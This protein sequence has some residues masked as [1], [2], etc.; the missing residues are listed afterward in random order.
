MLNNLWLALPQPWCLKRGL[1][2][3]SKKPVEDLLPIWR[4]WYFQITGS[5]SFQNS[6]ALYHGEDHLWNQLSGA[7]KDKI[8]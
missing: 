3:V 5:V 1:E 7:N 8:Q 6:G 2:G 4:K